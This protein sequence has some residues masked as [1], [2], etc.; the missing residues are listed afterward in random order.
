M[1]AMNLIKQT[2]EI[3][4]FVAKHPQVGSLK[5]KTLLDFYIVLIDCLVDH[6]HLYYI[7]SAPIISDKEY[8]ELF[9]YL[10]KIEEHHPEIISSNSPTQGLV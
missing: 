6:N 8:D 5:G 2:R 7:D 1:L 10:K 9:D 3:Q 4:N